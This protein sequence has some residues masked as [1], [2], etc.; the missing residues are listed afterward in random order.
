MTS[1][2]PAVPDTSGPTP[3]SPRPPSPTPPAPA[4]I[5]VEEARERILGRAAPNPGGDRRPGRRLEPRHRRAR[6]RPPDPAAGRRL[7]DGRLRP[8]RRGRHARR[9]LCASSAAP[10]PAI[11]STAASAPARRCACSPAASCPP[12]AD[13]ILLQEDA[14]RDGDTVRVNEAV[15]AS[16]HIRRA[17]QDFAAGDTVV[18]A[19]RR[20][21]RAR[22]RPRRRRQPPLAQ[23]C[24]AARASPSWPPATRSPCPASRSRPA[25]SSVPT[26]TPWPPWCAPPAASPSCCRSPATTSRRSPRPPTRCG[27][28]DMLVT[29][30]GAWVGDHD[31]VIEALQPARHD[32]GFLADRHAA[33][34]A[35][36]VR[37]ARARCRCSAC[38]ATRS[39]PW[40]ARC[41]SCCPHWPACRACPATR[42]RPSRPSSAP[43]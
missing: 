22:C 10:P 43:R 24:T 4:M 36:A 16:R 35:A 42:R 34:Q 20:H 28:M 41:C 18:A 32:A 1:A 26:P 31:L 39:P 2:V 5:S 15:A 19:G 37:P 8:A 14:T 21:D 17:G 27:G 9:Q 3:P 6:A 33:R 12:G 23:P 40:S 13:A 25:A 11:R 29:T 7:G 38:P 30:G